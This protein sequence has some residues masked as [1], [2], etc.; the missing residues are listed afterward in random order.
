VQHRDDV[1]SLSKVMKW[2]ANRSYSIELQRRL[3]SGPKLSHISVLAV[4][5]GMKPTHIMA[6][7]LGWLVRTIMFIVVHI[8]SRLPPNSTFRLLHKSANDVLAAV[9][10]ETGPL[11]GERPKACT[12]AGLK[13]KEVSVEAR[14]AEKRAAVWKESVGYAGLKEGDTCLADWA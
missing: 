8:S 9:A 12:L 4:D 5:P 14:D 3:D 13:S 2:S 6:A 11:Y 10:M 7:T 1:L